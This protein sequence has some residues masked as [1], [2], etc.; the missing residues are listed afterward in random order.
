VLAAF[1]ISLLVSLLFSSRPAEQVMDIT[2]DL[3]L[4]TRARLLPRADDPHDSPVVIIA[5]DDHTLAFA[6]LAVPEL[7]PHHYY[8]EV[9]K[10]LDRAGAKGVALT[11]ILPRFRNDF[12][13]PEDVRLWFDSLRKLHN[14]SLVSGVSWRPSQ[15]VLP[16]TDYLLS[17]DPQSFGFLNLKRDDDVHV[18]RLPVRWPDCAS[19]V[20]CLSLSFLAARALRPDLPEPAGDIFIDFDPRPEAVPVASFL[21]VYRRTAAFEANAG[22]FKQFEGK[23]VLIGELNFLNRGTWATPFSGQ[24]GDGDTTVEITAQAVLSLLEQRDFLMLGQPWTFFSLLALTGLALFP[25]V[26]TRRYGPYP[27]LRLPAAILPVYLALAGAAFVAGRLYLPIL[28]GALALGLAQI[29]AFSLRSIES[30]QAARTSLTAL[31]LYVNPELAEQIVSHPESLARGGQRREMTVFFS[32]L[33]GFTTLAEH[34]S[35]EALV[36]S[37]NRYFETM[38]PIISSSCGILDKFG[39]DSIMAFWGAPLL[40]RPDHAAAACLAALEQQSALARLNGLL[41]AEGQM[42]LSAL[43]GLTTG[44][45]VVGNIGAET[46]LNYTVMGDAVNLASRLV[47]VNKIYQTAIIVGEQ[48]A[49]EAAGA[50]EC[51]SLD[52][53]TVPGRSVSLTIFEVMGARGGLNDQQQRGRDLFEAGLSLYFNRDFQKAL[54]LFEEALAFIQGDGPAELMSGRCRQYLMNPPADDWDGVTKL[55]AK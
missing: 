22:F 46:R 4:Q 9:I 37:L 51:R 54:G 38:E 2:Y 29:F 31:S 27:G 13:P 48:T 6:P 20:G 45:M 47:A 42:P 5:I 35:P 49:R 55:A 28:P 8:L 52:R 12:S 50:V 25:L 1:I 11:R 26:L 17:M 34:I 7:F 53:I 41:L 14:L 43:M 44:P 30:R 15:I 33:V 39:G 24:T 18:R 32:D 40:E 19:S 10:A 23:L 36:A 16:A 21:D 3:L